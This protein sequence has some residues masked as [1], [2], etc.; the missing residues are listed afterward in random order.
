MTKI[1]HILSTPTVSRYVALAYSFIVALLA[2]FW[3]G[4]LAFIIYQG[5]YEFAAILGVFTL[6]IIGIAM[7]NE[8]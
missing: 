2:L 4:S 7:V 3:V 5:A 1:T 8:R 6:F